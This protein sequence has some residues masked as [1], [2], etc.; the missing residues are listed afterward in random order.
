MHGPSASRAQGGQP[1]QPDGVGKAFPISE[2]CSLSQK[3]L[4]KISIGHLRSLGG[5]RGGDCQ[6]WSWAILSL[7][8]S[9]L[10][11]QSSRKKR[12]LGPSLPAPRRANIMTL[13]SQTHGPSRTEMLGS[14]GQVKTVTTVAGPACTAEFQPYTKKREHRNMRHLIPAR[15]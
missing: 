7:R 14:S 2:S 12:E 11:L 9:T 5:H 15:K 8:S 4:R 6:P 10:A 1:R 3:Q 13:A